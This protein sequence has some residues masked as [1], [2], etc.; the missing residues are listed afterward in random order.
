MVD[1][2]GSSEVLVR[3]CCGGARKRTR[4]AGACTAV[5]TMAVDR[6]LVPSWQD[7]HGEEED[8]VAWR[9]GSW[10]STCGGA[11]GTCS[12]GGDSLREEVAWTRSAQLTEA[13]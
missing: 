13:R 4:R 10:C 5:G 3:R 1:V 9:G 8:G 2:D 12:V 6:C 7:S 11:A